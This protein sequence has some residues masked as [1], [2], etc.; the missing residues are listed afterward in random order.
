MEQAA[1]TFREVSAGYKHRKVLD[2]VSFSV[3]EGEF[4]SLIG[5]NG[6]G[7]STLLKTAA[8]LL[9]PLSGVVELFG[10]E[11]GRAHV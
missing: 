8:A 4:V 3:R 5:P 10:Q 1:L 9:K 6:C 7:K 11:I 2:N